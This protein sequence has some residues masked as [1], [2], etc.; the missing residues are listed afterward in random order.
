MALSTA[1][2]IEDF[3]DKLTESAD[4]MNKRRVAAAKIKSI[5]L[6]DSQKVKEQ[7]DLLRQEANSLYIDT[8]KKV[9]QDLEMSQ[10]EILGII[11]EAKSRI[12]RIDKIEKVLVIVTQLLDLVAKVQSADIK[13][14]VSV[15]EDLKSQ[16]E[17]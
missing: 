10:D 4:T 8:A 16:F 3:A 14:V 6:E 2:E 13:G 9:L 7:C 11:G 15:S 1:K 17:S 12:E 5:S